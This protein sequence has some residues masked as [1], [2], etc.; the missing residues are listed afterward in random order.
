MGNNFHGGSEA[1]A[2]HRIVLVFLFLLSN[3]TALA[4]AQVPSSSTTGLLFEF[5]PSISDSRWQAVVT[6]LVRN[7]LSKLFGHPVVLVQRKHISKG[8]EFSD[9]VQ[10]ALRGDC[11]VARDTGSTIDKG[12]LGWVYLV[13]GRIDPCVLVDCD[14]IATLLQRELRERP[15]SQRQHVM[16]CAISHVIPH[17]QTHIVTQNPGH[18]VAGPL[19]GHVTKGDLLSGA[20]DVLLDGAAGVSTFVG[21][22]GSEKLR[23]SWFEGYAPVDTGRWRGAQCI[24]PPC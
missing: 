16:A 9:V 11:A 4:L 14:R 3:A 21:C 2:I 12:P 20:S 17:E 15:T 5:S 13:D 1:V 22:P 19:K 24:M 10:I 18:Q 23:A 8:T 7:D 6:A